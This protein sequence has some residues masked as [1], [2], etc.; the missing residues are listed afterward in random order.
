MALVRFTQNIQR[1]VPCPPT[2][3]DAATVR[4]ALEAV[5][6]ENARGLGYFLDDQGSLRK[7]VNIF[8][9]GLPIR[10]RCGLSDPLAD[11]SEVDVMQALSGG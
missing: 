8:V 11:G 5:F 10:D 4:Q 2:R 7:H 9:D 1:H 6:R 3:V